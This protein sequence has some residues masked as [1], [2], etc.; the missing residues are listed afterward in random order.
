LAT[1]LPPIPDELQRAIAIERAAPSPGELER[2]TVFAQVRSSLAPRRT[3]WTRIR[4]RIA[5]NAALVLAFMLAIGAFIAVRQPHAYEDPNAVRPLD[6]VPDNAGSGP[7][8][9]PPRPIPL[10]PDRLPVPASRTPVL[11]PHV[12]FPILPPMPMPV[13]ADGGAALAADA[14]V[15]TPRDTTFEEDNLLRMARVALGRGD[16]GAALSA[17]RLHIARFPYGRLADE[18]ELLAVEALVRSGH[19]DQARERAA[20]FRLAH[21]DS[22]ALHLIDELLAHPSDAGHPH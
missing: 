8:R 6:S 22:L 19:L 10:G 1:E 2:E 20:A 5:P 21:P 9:P 16:I 3:R 13:V 12:D 11:A 17:I 7:T 4:E 14:A 15:I 18:R